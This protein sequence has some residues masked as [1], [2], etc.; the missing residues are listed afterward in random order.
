M[1]P[2]TPRIGVKV[3]ERAV[4]PF[5]A[6]PLLLSGEYAYCKPS[7]IG[8]C[9]V[10]FFCDQS[11]VLGRSICCQDLRNRPII[12]TGVQHSLSPVTSDSTEMGREQS[13]WT[14]FRII[15]SRRTPWYIKQR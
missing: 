4:C 8:G 3:S 5:G 11:F 1:T 2:V 9:P 14:P 13:R 15:S 7:L 12:Q 6:D 10:G